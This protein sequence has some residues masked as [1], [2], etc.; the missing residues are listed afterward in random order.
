MAVVGVSGGEAPHPSTPGVSAI[1]PAVLDKALDLAHW[2]AVEVVPSAAEGFRFAEAEMRKNGARLSGTVDKAELERDWKMGAFGAFSD[3]ML[4]H[5]P[6]LLR[7]LFKRRW[8]KTYPK[9]SWRDGGECGRLIYHGSAPNMELPG[10]VSTKAKD[11]VVLPQLLPTEALRTSDWVK[12]HLGP[13]AASRNSLVGRRVAWA[14]QDAV[15]RAI[16]PPTGMLLLEPRA[17]TEGEFQYSI[18]E[19]LLTQRVPRESRLQG[20][21]EL[22]RVFAP[23]HPSRSLIHGQLEE[24]DFY[25]LCFVLLRSSHL[26]VPLFDT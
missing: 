12:N 5:V 18:N 22:M 13:S 16:H 7:L 3:L 11:G 21:P 6:A 15:V 1:T 17:P 2:Y 9:F 14:G 4:K 10:F 26:L 8:A 23:G 25:L 24:W 19:T 20:D